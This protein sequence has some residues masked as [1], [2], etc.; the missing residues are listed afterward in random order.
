MEVTDFFSVSEVIAAVQPLSDRRWVKIER[1]G[2]PALFSKPGQ[3]LPALIARSATNPAIKKQVIS[4]E[5]F[6][7]VGHE[8]MNGPTTGRT[9][10]VYSQSITAHSANKRR[11]A[12]LS[13]HG[14][15]EICLTRPAVCTENLNP[16]VAVMKS[17]QKGV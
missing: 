17:A 3:R 6:D 14:I 10:F 13:D 7:S 8:G 5:V 4:A 12:L 9:A 2:R 1:N 15:C 11:R 16:S